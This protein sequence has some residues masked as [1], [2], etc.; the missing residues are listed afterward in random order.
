MKAKEKIDDKL[1]QEI[2]L[3]VIMSFCE[4]LAELGYRPKPGSTEERDGCD[5]WIRNMKSKDAC[6][7]MGKLLKI[8]NRD[9][10]RTE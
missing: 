5:M 4:N 9:N 7:V 1:I 8:M 6:K 3:W 2:M 10:T